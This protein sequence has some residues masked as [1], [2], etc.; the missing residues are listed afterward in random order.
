MT[1]PD[2]DPKGKQR[3]LLARRRQILDTA[4]QLAEEEGWQA[5]TTRRLADA[6]DYSQPVIY[7]HFENRDELIHTLVIEGFIALTDR[8]H[9][10]A[11]SATI[12]LLEDLAKA[13]IDFG[14]TRRRLYE[15]MFTHPTELPL[16]LI[17]I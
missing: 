3:R 4:L 6:I 17:H 8:V 1:P 14:S 7:Q 15:A 12:T 5:V 13:Y 11:Q 16:S 9:A 10:V 2:Q